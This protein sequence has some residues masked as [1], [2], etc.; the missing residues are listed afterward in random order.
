MFNGFRIQRNCLNREE[1]LFMHNDKLKESY[2]RKVKSAIDLRKNPCGTVH[3]EFVISALIKLAG[4]KKAA[5]KNRETRI[6]S[7]LIPKQRTDKEIEN[8][9]KLKK[10]IDKTT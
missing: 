9:T 4:Q 2:L 7:L 1:E 6:R 5:K 8:L 10:I 3:T